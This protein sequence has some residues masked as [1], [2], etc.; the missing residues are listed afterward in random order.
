[1]DKKYWEQLAEVHQEEM[2]NVYA[3][4]RKKIISKCIKKLGGRSKTVTDLGCAYGRWLPVLSKNYKKVFAVD[5]SESFIEMAK[6]GN[7]QYSNIEYIRADAGRL[8]PEPSDVILCINAVM[9]PDPKQRDDFFQSIAAGLKKNGHLIL[10]VPSLES[11][12]FTE[13]MLDWWH[14]RDQ[15]SKPQ[16][17]GEDIAVKYE[18]LRSG[19]FEL[20]K[21]PT[22]HY[23]KEEVRAFLPFYDLEVIETDKIEYGWETEFEAP[24]AWLKKPTPWDWIFLAKKK[25]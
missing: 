24:P 12:L 14:Y 9:T 20:D 3:H 16:Y 10:V 6:A 15:S 5:I 21:V 18:N 25:K 22:K 13:A 19:I 17:Q 1:M 23:L 2:F 11:A 7:K 4:D 8:K